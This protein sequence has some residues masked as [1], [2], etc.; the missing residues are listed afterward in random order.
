MEFSES[1]REKVAVLR[2]DG[3]EGIRNESLYALPQHQLALL[4][5]LGLR[6]AWAGEGLIEAR[7]PL[8][9]TKALA[10]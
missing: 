4:P 9:N 2:A 7:K 10:L 3:G 5:A 8:L 6:T 1:F